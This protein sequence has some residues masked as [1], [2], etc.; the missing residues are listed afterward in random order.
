MKRLVLGLAL[1]VSLVACAHAPNTETPIATA[2]G[3]FD[4]ALAGDWRDAKNVARDVA[5]H[6]RET[7][8]FFGVRPDMTVLE[9]WPSAGWYTEVLAPSLREHGQ[10]IGI[11]NDPLKVASDRS[12]DDYDKQNQGL[13]A[14]LA[15]RPDVYDRVELREIDPAAPVLGPADSADAVLTFRNVHNWV[16][17]GT[18]ASMFEAFYE[19]LKPGGVL[20]VVDHRARDNQPPEEMRTSGYLPEEYVIALAL[21]AGFRLDARSEINA[22]GKDTKDYPGG[23][24]TLPPTLEQGEQDRD[25]YLAIGESDRMTLRFVKPVD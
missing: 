6:P 21:K 15:A 19:V 3:P 20:G 13:R 17:A 25:R 7:L 18:E 5:R 14:K 4:A 16:M 23:V 11:V 8:D 22:N 2:P 12:R 1:A 24:W 9:I 10:Y